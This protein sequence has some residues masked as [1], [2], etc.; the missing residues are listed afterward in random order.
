MARDNSFLGLPAELRTKIYKLSGLVRFCPINILEGRRNEPQAAL[1]R[2]HGDCKHC[3]YSRKLS[4]FPG[5]YTKRLYR[6]VECY[7]PSLPT[8]LLYVSRTVHDEAIAVLYGQNRFKVLPQSHEDLKV[9]QGLSDKALRAI[10]SLHVGL[11]PV[12]NQEYVAVD[13][14]GTSA[15][16]LDENSVRG[17]ETLHVWTALCKLVASHLTLPELHFS[18]SCEPQSWT[19]VA[20]IIEPLYS[21]PKVKDSAVR[22]GS[23]H[24][25]STDQQKIRKD[26]SKELVS[27]LTGQPITTHGSFPFAKL[28]REIRKMVLQ[29]TDLVC[30]TVES[31]QGRDAVGD[32]QTRWKAAAVLLEWQASHNDAVAGK[33]LRLFSTFVFTEDALAM[34]SKLPTS[35]LKSMRTLDFKVFDMDMSMWSISPDEL[36]VYWSRLT[37]FINDNLLVSKLWISIDLS[38]MWDDSVPSG[39]LEWVLSVYQK[40][41]SHWRNVKGL[42]RFHVFLRF[43]HEH[44]VP[45]EREVM[46]ETY[47][48][49]AEGKPS[50]WRRRTWGYPHR[51]PSRDP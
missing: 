6:S 33:R 37:H 1:H 28:P 43:F 36:Y 38:E 11:D 22:L 32:A 9:L 50:D 42:Q 23:L 25:L 39:N 46:G 7:C 4:G 18:F 41:I 8:Q 2:F 21:L 14:G 24:T 19:A 15:Y 16:A 27:F 3:M 49:A 5:R 35:S 34:L 31:N 30:Q 10:K 12:D 20:V 13:L 40:I 17:R 48:S 47:D 44:E 45:L 51:R 26:M 29:H